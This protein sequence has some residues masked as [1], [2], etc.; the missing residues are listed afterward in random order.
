MSVQATEATKIVDFERYST[1]NRL[2]GVMKR[3]FMFIKAMRKY[4]DDYDPGALAKSFIIKSIQGE[5][6]NSEINYLQ[7]KEKQ[8]SSP[9][10]V[11]QLDLFIDDS[12]ILR[13][14]GRINRTL[15]YD[16]NI[17]NPIVLPS[18][19][20]VT[21]LIICD[22]HRKCMHLGLQTTINNIRL[23]GFWIPRARQVVKNALSDCI[24][25][26]KF[27][28]FSYG[29]PKMTDISKSQMNLVR[30]FMHT[31]IDYTGAL[32]THEN[33][34]SKKMYILLYVHA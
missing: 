20:H 22:H 16:T 33:G 17:L 11:N 9:S 5:S 29:Y 14:K 1:Y 19:H 26:R 7:N 24:T 21:R 13:S 32:Y 3:T 4:G 12:G 6:F 27:N 2:F 23:S 8:N 28:S 31:G 34:T 30:P 15:Y 18:N 25:C 10:L